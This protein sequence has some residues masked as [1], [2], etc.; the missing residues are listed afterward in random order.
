MINVYTIIGLV[1]II[2]AI[3]LIL[4]AYGQKNTPPAI[5]GV[6]RPVVTTGRSMPMPIFIPLQ[7]PEG[8]FIG[9]A[10]A[11]S[12]TDPTGPTNQ[13]QGPPT[14][15]IECSYGTTCMI[16]GELMDG[17]LTI[18]RIPCFH[19]FHR[20]CLH[21]WFC[22]QSQNSGTYNCPVCRDDKPEHMVISKLV[23][24]KLSPEVL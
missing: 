1:M 6:D 2:F 9:P 5:I 12:P 19:S 23:D 7:E 10:R 21:H 11:I 24:I 20:V 16:C 4:C 3:V 22:T 14:W 8:V 13:I 15:E 17:A 18:S